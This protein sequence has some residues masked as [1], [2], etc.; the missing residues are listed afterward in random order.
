MLQAADGTGLSSGSNLVLNGGVFQSSGTFS[1]SLGTGSGQVQWAA[2]ANGGFAAQGGALTVTIAG[3]P[4]P[5]VWDST[6]NFVSGAGQL[7]FGSIT[8]DEVVTFTH[9]I[10]LNSTGAALSRTVSVTD[11]TGSTSDRAELSGV[12][13]NS[14]AAGGLTKAGNGILRLNANNSFTGPVTVTAGTLQFSTVSNNGGGVSNLG[15]GTDGISLATGSLSFVGS[16]N[17]STDRAVTLTGA[18][19]LDASGTSGATM[20]FNGAISA[21]GN[22]LTLNGTGDGILN[23]VVTQTGTT[24]DLNKS[25]T[26]TWRI[27]VAQPELADDIFINAGTLILNVA[28][29]HDGDDLFIRAGTLQ[30]G[31]NGALTNTMDDLNVST[32]TAGGGVL[33]VN[34]TTG[35]APADIILGSESLSGSIIDSIGTGSIGSTGTLVFRNGVV[36]ANLTG[37]AA[38]TKNGFTTV[39][40]SGNNV[41][42]TGTTTLANGTLILDYTTNNGEKL[43]DSAAFTSSGGGNLT[44]NGN[45]SSATSE[46]LGSLTLNAGA[47]HIDVN[48]GT[49]QTA[50]LNLGA[51]TRA[52]G[53]TVEFN[54]SSGSAVVQTSSVNGANTILGGYATVNGSQ[55]ASVSGGAIQGLSSTVSNNLAAWP[56]QADITDSTGYTGTVSDIIINSLRFNAAGATSAVNVAD[57]SRLTLNSGGILVTPNVGSGTASIS[58]GTLAAGSGNE[59]IVHQNNTGANFTIGSSI[60]GSHTL[61]K[62][63]AGTLLLNGVNAYTGQTTI[64]EGTVLLG[65]GSAIGDGSLVA[66]KSDSSAVLD[67]NNGSET[68]AGLSSFGLVSTTGF[69]GGT[70]AIGSGTLTLRPTATRA[71][72]GTITGSGTLIKTGASTQELYGANGGFSGSVMVNQGLINLSVGATVLNTATA[73]TLNGGELLSDQESGA[74]VDHI[75][76]TAT[77]LL[78]NTGGTRGV[79]GRNVDQAGSRAE[80][81]GAITLG[82]GHNVIQVDQNGASGSS[83]RVMTL[84]SASLA[85]DNHATLLVRG[86]SLGQSSTDRGQLVFSTAPGGTVGGAGAAGTTTMPI[87]P[88]IIGESATST[89]ATLSDNLG[90]SFV[91]NTGTTNGLRPLDLTTEY[92]LNEAGY[93]ALTGAALNN[94]RFATNPAATLTGSASQINSLVLDSSAG[95]LAVNGPVST[96]NI[97]SGAILA[98]TTTGAN[99]ISLGGFSSLTTDAGND[100]IVYVTNAANTFTLNSAL[101]TVTPLVKSGVGTLSLTNTGNAFTDVY[102]NEGFVQVDN[103]DKLGTGELKFFGGGV[104]LAA[105]FTGDI[106]AK[107]W[108]ISTGGGYLDAGSVTGGYTLANGIDDSTVSSGDLFTII[109]RPTGSTGTNGQLTIQGASTFTGTTVFNHT[110]LNSGTINSVVL[111]GATNQTINGNVHLGN[112]GTIS[113][114]SLDVVVAL[115]ADEQ[116]VNTATITFNSSSGEEAY[117]K[118]MG[119]TETV[120][121]ISAASRGVIENHESATDTTANNGKLIVNSSQNFSY[122]GFLRDAGSTPGSTLAFEKQGTGTQTLIGASISHTGLTTISG[123][124]LQLQGVTAWNSDIVNNS[125]LILDETAARTHTRD[126]TGTGSLIKQGSAALTLAGGL[127]LTYTGPT[128][129]RGGTMTVG[130][131]INGTTSLNVLNSGSTLALTGGISNASSITNVVVEHGGTLS[132]LDGVGNKLSGLTNLQ[133]GSFGGTMTT[134]NLNVGD[135]GTAGD[136]LNTDLL[137]LLTGGTLSLFSGNQITFNLTDAGLNP[138][139]TYNLLSVVDGGLTS[140]VLSNLDYLLGATPGG[141]TSITLNKTNNLISITTGTLITGNS[142]WNAGGALDNWNDVA[143]WAITDKTGTI[144][145]ASIPGQGTDVIFIA[146]NITGGGGI[147]TTLEQNFKVNSLT[148]EASTN[149]SDTPA[150]VT[151]APGTVSTSRLE[152]APQVASDGVE[153]SSGGP[154]AV[155]ISAPFKIGAAQTWTV[156]DASRTLTLS[157]G[158]QGEGDVTKAGAGKVVLSAVADPTFNTGLTTDVTIGVGTIEITNS[159]ALGT[160]AS[161]N[162]ANVIINGG[163]FYYNNA[164]AGTVANPI[165]LAGG[166]LSAGGNAHT[167]SGAVNI[168][169]ASFINMADSNTALTGAARNITLSGAVSGSGTLTID[170]NNTASAGN[171]IGGTLTINNA[172][173]TWN[174][175]LVFNRGTVTIAS[176]ASPTV[177]PASITFNSFGKLGLNGVDGQTINL[178][179]AL[180]LAAGAVAEL[181]LDNATGTPVTDYVV[182]QNGPVT[183]GSSGTGGTLRVLLT[184]TQSRFNLVGAVTLGG[185]S[186]ISVANNA[187]RIL[188]ID[189]IISDGGSGYALTINDDAGGWAQTNGTVRL[190]ALNTFSGNFA[191]GEGIAEFDT[192]TDISG[193]A[194]SLGNGTAITMG[195]A[196]LSFIGSASQSTNRPLATTGS[197]SLL[198]NGTAGATITYAGAIAQ[199]TDNSLTLGGTGTGIISGGISQPVGAA[200]ADLTVSGG[201]W[202]IK[203][204]NVNTSDDFLMTGGTATL[205]NMVLSVNDD[206][207]N[208]AGV[209]NLNTAGVWAPT[210]PSGTSSGLFARGGGV[211]NLGANDINGTAN[212]NGADFISLGDGTTLG[213]GTLDTN[214]YS[215][216]IPQ[217][218]VGAIA[219]GYTGSVLDNGTLTVTS[220]AV[221]WSSGIRLYRGSV[222]AKLAGVASILKQGLGDVTLSGDNS[223]LTGTV[224]ATRLDAGNLILDFTSDNNAKISTSAAL[225]MRGASLMVNGSSSAATSQTVSSTTLA[226]GG[227]GMMTVNAGTGQTAVLN[228]NAITRAVNS[229]DGTMRFVLPTG[230]QSTSN[231]ITTDTLNTV[232]TGTNAILGGWATVDDGTGV[233]FARNATGAADG[234][235]VAAVTTVQDVIASWVTGDNVSDGTGFSGTLSSA[236]VNSLRFDAVAGSD[237]VMTA[238]GVLGL[239][240]GGL[241]VTSNVAGT[242]SITNGTLF[243]GAAAS[244]VPELMITHDSPSVFEIGADIRINHAVTKSGS[245]TL[246]LTGNNTYT[247]YTEIQNGTLRISGGNAIGDSSLVTLAD[248]HVV[249]LELL[250]NET[251][252]RLQGGSSTTGLETLATVAIGSNT[253]TVNQ[254]GNTTYAGLFTGSGSL[255]LSPTSTGNLQVTGSSTGFTGVVTVNGGLL[256][257]SS[258]GQL[259][260]TSFTIN[261]GGML[262][263]DNNG[264]TSSTARILD[265]TPIV[266]NSATGTSTNPRGLWVRNT[267]NNSSRV[268]TVGVVTL[269]SGANY[270]TGEANVGTGNARAGLAASNY[271]RANNATADIRARNLGTTTTHNIQF[272][273]SNSTN[274]TAFIAAMV[275][276]ASTTAGTKNISIVPWAIG[277]THNNSTNVGTNMGNSLVTYVAGTGFRPLDLSTEYNTYSAAGTTDNVRETLAADLTGLAGK[278]INALVINNSNDGAVNLSVTGA[279]AGQA[280]AVTSGALLFTRAA[281]ATTGTAQTITLGGFDNGITVGGASPEYIIHVVNPDAA[282]ATKALNAAITS[283]LVTLADIT[284]S[285]RGTLILSGTNT[286]GGGTKKTTINEGVLEIADLDNIGGDTGNLVFGG[287]T[288]RL[289]SAFDVG[290][291]ILSTR[292]ISFL[293]GGGTLDTN[294]KDPVLAGS[295]GSGV[296]GFTKTGAG[297]LTLNST[298]TYTGNTVLSSGTITVGAANALGNGG[299]LTLAGGTTLALGTNSLTHGLVTTS[300]ASPAI[301]GTGTITASTGFFLNHTGDT[302][303]DAIL[304]GTGG[305]LKAQTNEVT[306]TAASTYTG[307]TE[308]Q[309]GT[310]SF[311][312]IGNVG[313]AASA[314]GKPATVE[315]GIIRMGLTTVGATLTYTGAA[316]TTDRLI[317]MQ[318]TTGGVTLNG[319]GTGGITYGGVR[320]ENAGNKTLTLGGTSAVGII[321]SIGNLAENG[322]VLAV[323]KTDANT[324]RLTGTNTYTGALT[325]SGGLLQVTGSVNNSPTGAGS[326]TSIGAAAST[327]GSL[328]VP[329]GGSLTTD[330]INVGTNATGIGSLVIRGGTVSTTDTASTQTGISV[331]TAGYGALLISGGS[332]TTN[333]IS[334]Y[335]SATGTG[336]FQLSGGTVD[337][338]EFL[339]MS[340]LRSEFTITGGTLDRNG[341]TQN[342][343]IGHN[344]AGTSV[345]NIAGGTVDNTGS[346]VSFGQSTGTPTS[347]LNLTGGTLTTNPITVANTPT[348]TV[349]FNG[350][351]LRAAIDSTTFVPLNAN[352]TTYVHAGGAVIDSNGRTITIPSN[353]LSPASSSGVTG[354]TLAS[355]GSGYIGAPY[356]E[357]TGGGGTG[358]TGYATIDTDPASPTYGQVTGVFLSNPGTGYT[359]TPSITLHGGGGTGAGVTVNG[360]AANTSGGLTKTGLG[361]LNLT[362]ANTFTGVTGVTGGTLNLNSVITSTSGL[363]ATSGGTLNVTNSFGGGFDLGTVTVGAGSALNFFNNAADTTALDALTGLNLGAGASGAATLGLELGADSAP[364]DS[365]MTSSVATLANTVNFNISPLTGFGAGIYTL[366]TGGVGSGFDINASYTFSLPA[367]YVAS[368]TLADTFVKLN[369]AAS[370]AHSEL[371]W[372]GG[373]DGKWGSF[374]GSSNSNWTTDLA[375]LTNAQASPDATTTAYFSASNIAATGTLTTT[376]EQAFTLNGLVFNSQT[377]SG[378]ITAIAINPGAAGSLILAPALASN[379]IAILAGAPAGVTIAAPLTLGAAQTWTVADSGSLLSVSGLVTGSLADGSTGLTLTGAGAVALSNNANTFTGDIAVDGATLVYTSGTA[380]TT[381]G[382]GQGSAT[383]YKQILLSNGGIFQVSGASFNVNVNS[384]TNRAAGA[385]FNIGAGGGV[386]KVDSGLTFSVDD[387]TAAG[388]GFTAAQLQ[389]NGPLTKTG[390]GILVLRNQ[391][392]FA[393]TITVA[394]GTLRTTGATAFGLNTAG[395]TILSGA[396]LDLNDQAVTDN[397]PLTISGSG[398]ASSPAGVIT[399]SA[400]GAASFVGPITLDGHSTIGAA[401]AGGLTLSGGITGAYDLTI[402]NLAAGGTTLS[403]ATV[404]NVGTI[405]NSSTGTGGAT[406]SAVIGGNVTEV[407]QNSATSTL[408]LGNASANT[409]AALTVKAGTVSGVT[410]SGAFGAGTITLGDST[411]NPANVTL[412]GFIPTA[413]VTNPIVLGAGTTGTITLATTNAT[414][415]FTYSGGVTGSNNLTVAAN[416]AQTLT[417]AGLVN[418]GGTITNAGTG[419]G[420][421]TLSGGVGSNVTGITQNS[422]TS[423]LVL[424][425]PNSYSGA[426][427]VIAGTLSITGALNS[428][429]LMTGL[430]VNGGATLNLVNG[431]GVPLSSLTSLSLGAGA[432]TATLGLELGSSSDLLTVTGAATTANSVIFNLTG[433]PGLAAGTYNLISATSGLSGASYSL[434]TLPGGFTYTFNT[435]D[436][437]VQLLATAV[438]GD[439]YWRGAL[440]SSWSTFSAG[441]TNWTTDLAGTVNANATPG[442]GSTVI[443]SSTTASGPTVATTLDGN[444]R[445]NDLKF[446]ATPAGV[447]AVTIA[448]GTPSTSSLT[449][450]PSLS[451]AGIE[452]ADNAGNITISAPV[453][454]GSD[455]TWNIVGT[456]ANG[457][458]L[459]VN[460]GLTG[461]GDITKNGAGALTLSAVNSTYDGDLIWNGGSLTITPAGTGANSF[462]FN[463]VIS[464]SGTGPLLKNGTGILALNGANTYTGGT[465]LN[466]GTTVLGNKQ[467]FSTGTVTT[468]TTAPTLQASVDLSGANALAN[469]FILDSNLTVS[470]TNNLEITGT[471]TTNAAN[472]TLTNNITGPAV[473]TLAGNVVLGDAGGAR[474]LTVGG[475]GS[476]VING[477]IG[478]GPVA[479]GGLVK[480]GTGTLTLGVAN[481][482]TGVTQ[483]DDGTLKLGVNDALPT[484]TALRLGTGT[485]AGTLDLN[486]FNQT[487]GSLTV[488]TNSDI[489]TNQII[490]DAGNTLTINGAVS[491][492]TTAEDGNTNLN[493]LG[494]GSVVV[495]SGNSN[496]IVGTALGAANSRVDVDFTG[497]SSFTANLGTGF[498]RLGDPNTDTEDNPSTFKLAENNTITAASIRIGDGSGGGVPTTHTLT[499]GSGSNTFNANTINIGSAGANIRSGGAVVFGGSDTTGTF[500]VRAS[501]GASRSVLNLMNTTGNTAGNMDST[502]NLAGHTADVLVSTLTMASRSAGNG[503]ATATLSFDQG[504]LDV[505]TLNMA[506]RT[507]SGTG[508]ATATLNLGDSVAPGVPTVTIGTL[509]MAV[510]TSSGGTVTAD[511]NVT[512]G[513]V[514]I[515]NGS[516]TA[517]NMANAGTGRTVTSTIDLT[518]GTVTVNGN[519]IRTGGVGTENATLTLNGSTL[520]MGGNSIGTGGVNINFAAQSGTLQ[521]LGEFNGGG[522]LTKTTAG[523]LTLGD[524]NTYTGGTAITGG[525]LLANNTTG[526]ATGTGAVTVNGGILGGSG[527]IAG[528]TTVNTTGVLAAGGAASTAGTLTLQGD[529]VMV[530]SG[531]PQTRLSFDFTNATGN[532]G[533]EVSLTGDWWSTYSGTLLSGNGGQSNDLVNLTATTPTITW[534]TGGMVSLNQLGSTYTWVLGDIL[535]LLDWNNVGNANPITGSFGTALTD[536]DLP[537]LG[538]GLAW[539]TSRFMSTGAIA[540]TPEPGRALLM[541]FG[542]LALFFRRRRR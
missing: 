284:K 35:S 292:T 11:N 65:G 420:T 429:G 286:A 135:V 447:T 408:T 387:G 532:A 413:N 250:S 187:A 223:G 526:S 443:F 427:S 131:P 67:L 369:V 444:F 450:A 391:N 350:G 63:G 16:T 430:T 23:G 356:V 239:G 304:A 307:T 306:L 265:T 167:Y 470:G 299:D 345:V 407:I 279:G 287:G 474:N 515:G 252:G 93:N 170:G 512:G 79:W 154:A 148:F 390:D 479:G 392:V 232:G 331:G 395:T 84:T 116:I 157:G 179:G 171:Q 17:Q 87:A 98:T 277:E 4:S 117:F 486:G 341:A 540:V 351:T 536:F 417:L 261:N 36:S 353:L 77:I 505:T 272:R 49:S 432:G 103:L 516:G 506:S 168:S 109:T 271:L 435:S 389:G 498:F 415:P 188:T 366:L 422:A 375:G 214:G 313:G 454:A 151:I 181:N 416:G 186:S 312:S 233:Y 305:L 325:V 144:S 365:L 518:G 241:L 268:E 19:T 421:T 102:L 68:V 463:G 310:L 112:T 110:G 8:A 535:N 222:A 94:V 132:L 485:T 452:V 99:A 274:E 428:P 114:N 340:N 489:V 459:T 205:Q 264:T 5:L 357:I 182:N 400:P 329:T 120:A 510:N 257:L 529:L 297:N 20:T 81:V 376:L 58:G 466:G 405:T 226:T 522:V 32:E 500:T 302:T 418:N 468:A 229:Q 199:G 231:G 398:L 338:N 124:T 74:S 411:A 455:Q 191:L 12:L 51:I 126:I 280:L 301:T 203:D 256:H 477:V 425:G 139:Q 212:A 185:N 235:I 183:L 196:T 27:D 1:R 174:G 473:L 282:D 478:N 309:A 503:F 364:Y 269:N 383:A 461:S 437:L 69:A 542:L 372:L 219:T 216:S 194:S 523:T 25:G 192:V 128:T 289:G 15:Q 348:A 189:S 207:V 275:G 243:S 483:V 59:L 487:I 149:P 433:L 283:Q 333:R 363:S 55:F 244:N 56:V 514:T 404:N 379:G 513:N 419:A 499:L 95:A 314:L 121:G 153:I 426:T 328:D 291:D 453:V 73:F 525:T 197:G 91:F 200:T 54:L 88:Y 97:K 472:R 31:V 446:T 57:G 308:V 451:T 136:N 89:D 101:T 119:F 319:S 150:S 381:S 380:T 238:S 221:D 488:E 236:Y 10:D 208:T 125:L 374:S 368:T 211:I 260:A 155:T 21:A 178:A 490:V 355:A 70:V 255:V 193:G 480:S 18:G 336:V 92:I 335:N 262:L 245:G 290:T 531:S 385:V 83:G 46:T 537:T 160:T 213:A 130:S 361:T 247:G 273:I 40:L 165:T 24:A 457:S 520:D 14:S 482:Y 106:G 75:G 324:W 298:A 330:L 445:V 90:N 38:M 441:N 138:G 172:G 476:T 253:L 410:G 34:G 166:T 206:I 382:L 133:L 248:D 240:S 339:I 7:L 431:T 406:I 127:N 524:G 159:G 209:L 370:S 254:T 249:T 378:A 28:D 344:L 141:F 323:T 458:S 377:N 270:L 294:G 384:S 318:G 326:S 71:Y 9:D 251:I 176:T 507:G 403:T 30:L 538:G 140:G 539:D 246:L 449:I 184:E 162:L 37:G 322:G 190:T 439:I 438:S 436:T 107:T 173:S 163:A 26:G 315:N 541:M 496:F 533:G 362:G 47:L 134:L 434:G 161:S 295:L 440:N 484:A 467:A 311:N 346:N 29:A 228:L 530:G 42:F 497:L 52:A 175:A 285:G 521:N 517:I 495:N 276:G 519:I 508:N 33:D 113:D 227:A 316:A 288:L 534:D 465:T 45:A 402:R 393:G 202:T 278:T 493:A 263:I 158:L 332:L 96:L 156:A 164:T 146:D 358:A 502:L 359:S 511:L 169:S 371:Y 494:G 399:N 317:G 373:I 111:N 354:L 360:I 475:A 492:G 334:L 237:V 401:A 293:L 460:G 501:D 456:G 64:N 388:T 180:T 6:A 201:T 195:A 230:T 448:P 259:N 491:I 464:G 394:E 43:S 100:F 321:N 86:Q 481:T 300:G 424:S 39:T 61:T 327:L 337:N 303:I 342:L 66:I 72:L 442:T 50:T 145:A 177:T 347:I 108:D 204:G 281:T 118:L 266:L 129:V 462:V 123:G 225:D 367:G 3:A 386:F 147:S 224:A 242:P 142:W 423:A 22:S 296:G 82:A 2:G 122:T 504:T 471:V 414:T 80:T 397:E 48:N 218:N 198:A 13:S 104:K 44:L 267:D 217:L 258:V 60:I 62:S 509:N 76:N 343:A 53:G 85:R 320:F 352:L 78:N 234:N 215:L 143:N 349:N 220:T 115:G 41:G 409:F 105:G 469:N 527:T 210:T 137:T 528:N 396:A 412:T 152:V